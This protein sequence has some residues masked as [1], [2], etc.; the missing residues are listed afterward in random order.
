MDF[1]DVNESS[2]RWVQ[3]FRL[4]AYSSPAKLESIDGERL[5]PRGWGR[6]VPGGFVVPQSSL[7]LFPEHPGACCQAL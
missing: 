5:R 3:D 7:T 4:K 6:G 2:A 1:V